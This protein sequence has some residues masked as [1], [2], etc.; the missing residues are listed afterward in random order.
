[1]VAYNWTEIDLSRRLNDSIVENNAQSQQENQ[2]VKSRRWRDVADVVVV[3]GMM[4]KIS[5]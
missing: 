3:V 4:G 5:R 1:M 2:K